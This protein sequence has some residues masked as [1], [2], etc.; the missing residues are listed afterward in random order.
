MNYG[1]CA[2]FRLT[3]SQSTA[4]H[5]GDSGTDIFDSDTCTGELLLCSSVIFDS[6]IKI[7]IIFP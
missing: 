3:D 2:G 1:I 5:K 6:D 7:I 4:A